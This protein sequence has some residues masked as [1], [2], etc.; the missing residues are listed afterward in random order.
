MCS[1]LSL[2]PKHRLASKHEPHSPGDPARHRRRVFAF[3]ESHANVGVL[4]SHKKKQAE[5]F[6]QARPYHPFP[7]VFS[8]ELF[9]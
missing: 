1:G 9:D 3:L 6:T 8:K 2:S 7:Q 5:A 4:R